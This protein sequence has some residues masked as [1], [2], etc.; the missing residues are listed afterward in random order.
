VGE[1]KTRRTARAMGDSTSDGNQAPTAVA[2][3]MQKRNQNIARAIVVGPVLKEDLTTAQTKSL[4]LEQ[5]AWGSEC[6]TPPFDPLV[7]SMLPENSKHMSKCIE[8][9]QVNI[10]GFGYVLKAIDQRP[11]EQIDPSVLKLMKKERVRLK[12]WFNNCLTDET[13][14]ELRMKTRKDLE[15][16]G[17][18][19]WEVVR[20][21]NGDITY[22]TFLPGHTI[23]LTPR[24]NHVGCTQ[25]VIEEQEDGSR[26][27]VNRRVMRRFRRFCQMDLSA[28]S[29]IGSARKMWFKELGDP[30]NLDCRTG[31]FE[32]PGREVPVQYRANEVIFWRIW[33]PRTPYGIPRYIGVMLD[34]YG[35]RAAGE[36]N[37]VTLRNN[38][39]PSM[40]LMVSNGQVTEASI[41]RL[42]QFVETRIQGK[43]NFSTFV[44]VEAEPTADAMEG[45]DNG[46]MKMA[47][48]KLTDQQMRDA[49]FINY[50]N[51][52]RR[53]IREVWRLPPLFVGAADDYTRATADASTKLADEQIFD[54]ERRMFDERINR[55]LL[56]ELQGVY[57]TFVSLGP[58][59]TNNQEIIQIM[60]AGEK[61]GA[62]TPRRAGDLVS[63]AL[64]RDLAPLDQEINPDIPFSLQM[65]EKVKN[66]GSPEQNSAP[67]N[68]ITAIKS[69][70]PLVGEF[71]EVMM[72]VK[73][74]LEIELS[75]RIEKEAEERVTNRRKQR[76]SVKSD[77]E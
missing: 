21:I 28:G 76:C 4:E 5:N 2:S 19:A 16:V 53:D 9:M 33:A 34:I 24:G 73:E 26:K 13:F 39:I 67:G 60:T 77:E 37:Y 66:M 38:N 8:A 48:E 35:D 58:N 32:A 75:R 27:I 45:Q 6:I 22:L 23:R 25:N 47:V 40:L 14:L 29:A 50:G 65:A 69:H 51:A 61:A 46:T 7:L 11:E 1:I 70:N 42:E 71:L 20:N 55:F 41:K 43:D 54:P 63:S 12:N 57:H 59:V 49:M 10:D 36:V 18:C 17:Y 64:G 44:I 56:T 62:M 68:T 31:E 15:S 52:N 30:R 3:Q 72:G 74:D